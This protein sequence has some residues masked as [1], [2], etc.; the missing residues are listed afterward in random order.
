MADQKLTELTADAAPTTD[1]LVY[2]VS[3]P[4]GSPVSR[5][6]TVA[7]LLGVAH[8]SIYIASG[9]TTQVTNAT[10]DTFDLMTGWNT[11]TGFNGPSSPG[12]TPAKASNK[13]TLTDTGFYLVSFQVSFTGSN[14]ATFD[15]AGYLGGVAQAHIHA[16][17]KITNVGDVGSAEFV[18]IVD[19]TI[20]QD[21]DVRIACDGISKDFVPSFAQLTVIRIFP[22]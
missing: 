18:G 14:N 19:N 9:V 12:V 6:V 20:A 8:G 16:R 2:T 11:A 1:D 21:L 5:K 4:A 10:P 13:I 3:D 15:A 22:T 7:N 17:R